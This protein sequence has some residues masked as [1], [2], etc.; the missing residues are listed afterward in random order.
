MPK[1]EEEEEDEDREPYAAAIR[2]ELLARKHVVGEGD[3]VQIMG[4]GLQSHLEQMVLLSLLHEMCAIRRQI[5][6]E[7]RKERRIERWSQVC[8][9]IDVIMLIVTTLMNAAAGLV[10]ISNYVIGFKEV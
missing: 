1:K 4:N 8:Y 3:W 9:R 7:L 5:D 6:R 2:N 10:W